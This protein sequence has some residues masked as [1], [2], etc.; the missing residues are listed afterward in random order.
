[1]YKQPL[2]DERVDVFEN[3]ILE[4]SGSPLISTTITATKIRISNRN[5]FVVWFKRLQYNTH[6]TPR[7]G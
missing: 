4:K 5:L 1:M 6:L 7:I 2:R 3:P